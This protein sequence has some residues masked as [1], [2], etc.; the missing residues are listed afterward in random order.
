[1]RLFICAQ[2]GRLTRESDDCARSELIDG[3]RRVAV[4]LGVWWLPAVESTEGRVGSG[5]SNS[6][7]I[8][9][10]VRGQVCQC[11]LVRAA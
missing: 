1:M 11:E 2:G 9:A 4:S 8:A 10:A 3:N 5:L 6:S 7:T